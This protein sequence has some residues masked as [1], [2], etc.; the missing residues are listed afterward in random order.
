MNFSKILFYICLSL[1]TVL[2]IMGYSRSSLWQGGV[3][4][5][6]ITAGWL[7]AGAKFASAC[8][9]GSVCLA[10]AGILLKAPPMFMFLYVSLSLASWDITMMELSIGSNTK[11]KKVD[12]YRYIRYLV[13]T[14]V[15]CMGLSAVIIGRHLSLKIPFL[16]MVILVVL[17]IAGF[18]RIIYYLRKKL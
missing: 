17:F 16:A 12:L 13:L 4:S 15:L 2:S 11:E 3:I 7:L 10:A 1:S 18:D 6:I 14:M 5:L 8:L 9:T